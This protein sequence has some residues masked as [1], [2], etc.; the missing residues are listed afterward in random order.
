L[1]REGERSAL[2]LRFTL[3]WIALLVNGIAIL[4]FGVVV[5]L[6]RTSDAEYLHA[7]GVAAIGMG[8]FG[9]L[10]TL[11]A[12]RRRERWAYLTLW[13]YPIFWTAHLVGDLPPGHDHIHQVAFI[14]LSVVGLLMPVPEF[15]AAHR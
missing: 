9:A 6:L 3:S 1:R 11:T 4:A 14:L 12:F 10:I 2:N 15:Y 7:I 8:L 13:Y 5:L